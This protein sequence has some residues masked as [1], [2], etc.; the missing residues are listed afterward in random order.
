MTRRSS[1]PFGV[2]KV[3]R[4]PDEPVSLAQLDARHD[5]ILYQLEELDHRIQTVLKEYLPQK[6][7]AFSFSEA[8]PVL[9]A[10]YPSL[11]PSVVT[12]GGPGVPTC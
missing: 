8:V 11:E 2:Q 5:D 3:G 7:T 10:E 1:Q 9:R 4:S 6:T 12:C